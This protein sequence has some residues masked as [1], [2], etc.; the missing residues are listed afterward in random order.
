MPDFLF[1]DQNIQTK[2][3]RTIFGTDIAK[4][5]RQKGFT[6]FVVVVSANVSTEDMI[7]YESCK[8][9]CVLGKHLSLER[10]KNIIIR[11]YFYKNQMGV[12]VGEGGGI[13][14]GVGVV[15]LGGE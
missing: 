3:G 14:V 5:I 9:D 13:G 15:G 11:E 8:V 4:R 1:V 6:G 12:E 10:K 7:F 2:D